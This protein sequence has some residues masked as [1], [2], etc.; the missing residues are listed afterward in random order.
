ML[1]KIFT[2]S[3]GFGFLTSTTL[4]NTPPFSILLAHISKNTFSYPGGAHEISLI[5][6]FN[7]LGKKLPPKNVRLLQCPI[8]NF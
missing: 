2:G 4:T 1:G 6:Q 3:I 5:Y 8:P 7:F